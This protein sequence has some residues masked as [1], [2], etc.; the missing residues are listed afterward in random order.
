MIYGMGTVF[1]FLTL[2]VFITGFMS[3]MLIKWFPEKQTSGDA[4]NQLVDPHTLT[5]LQ[6]AIDQ[7]RHRK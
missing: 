7:H 4:V 1:V 6:A 2:L 5:I 3:R